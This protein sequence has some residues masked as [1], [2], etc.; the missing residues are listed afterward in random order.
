[1]DVFLSISNISSIINIDAVATYKS[2]CRHWTGN[3][4]LIGLINGFMLCPGRSYFVPDPVA[5]H[6]INYQ[7]YNRKFVSAHDL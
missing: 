2:R 6:I 5:S 7:L 1:M 3:K 4:E